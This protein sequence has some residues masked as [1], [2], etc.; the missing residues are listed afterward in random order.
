MDPTNPLEEVK[1]GID[2][3]DYCGSR[4]CRQY[5]PKTTRSAALNTKEAV[6]TYDRVGIRET[7]GKEKR[8]N[9]DYGMGS[10]SR[11]AFVNMGASTNIR[12]C[13][14]LSGMRWI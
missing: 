4:T 12:Y 7:F 5:L 9:R 1:M 6:R 14:P 10:G 11:G 3:G 2:L 13:G 8:Y